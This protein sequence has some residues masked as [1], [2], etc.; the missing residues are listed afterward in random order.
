[1]KFAKELSEK[2]TTKRALVGTIGVGYVGSAVARGAA[3]AGFTVIGFARSNR[4]IE[5][6]NALHIKNLTAT[7][8]F[9]RLTSCDVLSLCVPTPVHRSNRPNMRFMS[10]ALTTVASHLRPGQLI[11]IESS[12]APGT[13]RHV[14]LPILETSG[15]VGG[16]D[17]FLSFS[18]ER[19]DP[20]NTSYDITNIPKVISGLNELSLVL[21]KQFYSSFVATVVPVSTLETAELTKVFENVFRFVNIGLATEVS[22]FA[23]KA[24]INMWEVIE[25]ASTKPF[26]FL[27]HYPGPGIGGDCIPVLPY[28]LLAGAKTVGVD[29]PIVRAAARVNMR[30]PRQVVERTL[31]L[32][33]G[34]FKKNNGK[35]RVL[36]VGIAYKPESSDL[37]Q[38]AALK[39]WE[40]LVEL[41]VNVSYHDPYVPKWNGAVSQELHPEFLKEQD[42][43]VIVTHHKNI[44]FDVLVEARTPVL[45]TRNVFGQHRHSHIVRL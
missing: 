9:S 17:F 45:D 2:I 41:G 33:N 19:I 39:I 40:L 36:L 20:G 16:E 11:T 8:D 44:P 31:E 5:G 10:Q 6:V 3:E 1:M 18:P 32:I 13:T 30:R 4:S 27:P 24:G 7:R 14:A 34:K 38:S 26:G 21:A 42:A 25:A 35:P 37:R 12:V 43:I 22:R 29:L 23:Q 15:L 28:Y